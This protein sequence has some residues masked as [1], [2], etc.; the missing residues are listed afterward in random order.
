M[1]IE[2]CRRGK[3]M[4]DALGDWERYAEKDPILGHTHVAGS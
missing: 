3:Q 2:A 1:T 4:L